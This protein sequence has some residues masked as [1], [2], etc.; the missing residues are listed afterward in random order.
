MTLLS[1]IP[2]DHPVFSASRWDDRAWVHRQVMHLFGPLESSPGPR[3]A[4]S[5]L[6]RVEPQAQGGRVLVQSSVPPEVSGFS[7][8]EL[9]P[10]LE[11]LRTGSEVLYL[12]QANPVRTVNRTGEDGVV[13]KHRAQVGLDL[14]QGWLSA[15][16]QGL[17]LQG[18][19]ELT[20]TYERFGK[21]PL[22]VVECRGRGVVTDPALLAETI[23]TGVGKARSY[24]CGM[25]SVVPA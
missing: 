7:T 22:Y 2:M 25:V 17:V 12:V 11:Q 24:G 18:E 15:R 19:P 1:A 16:L 3:A 5:I 4:S 13:R 8:K 20:R 23:R 14:M 10:L 21:T 6:F 9:S